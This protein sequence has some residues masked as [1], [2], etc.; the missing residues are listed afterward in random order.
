MMES[1]TPMTIPSSLQKRKR[2]FGD[3]YPAHSRW[4]RATLQQLFT[5]VIVDDS[6]QIKFSF[7]LDDHG[8]MRITSTFAPSIMENLA[9]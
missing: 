6:L 3:H 4:N 9:R 8:Q 2:A 5:D 1:V 7:L